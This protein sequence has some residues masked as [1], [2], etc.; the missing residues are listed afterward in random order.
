MTQDPKSPGQEGGL[1]PFS[2]NAVQ[3]VGAAPLP[4]PETFSLEKFSVC[5]CGS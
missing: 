5:F 3:P 4:N 1:P 2:L